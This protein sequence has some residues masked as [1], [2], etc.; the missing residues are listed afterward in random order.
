MKTGIVMRKK[1]SY[2]ITI[3]NQVGNDER[4]G[5]LILCQF[6][7][8]STTNNCLNQGGV[9]T[10][11]LSKSIDYAGDYKFL[12]E[13]IKNYYIDYQ[14]FISFYKIIIVLCIA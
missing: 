1:A 13:G 4:T 2:C 14:Y 8:I 6:N 10:L 9:C 5:E 3:P 11:N 12:V 7:P